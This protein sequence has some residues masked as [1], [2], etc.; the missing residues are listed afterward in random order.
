VFECFW[1]FISWHAGR[2]TPCCTGL[3]NG[4]LCGDVDSQNNP[5]YTV[6]DPSQQGKYFFWDEFHPTEAGWKSIFSLF[7]D[8]SFLFGFPGGF[9]LYLYTDGKSLKQFLGV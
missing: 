8:D 3:Q 1:Q 6:C 4:R 9:P 7:L 5:Q 2:L